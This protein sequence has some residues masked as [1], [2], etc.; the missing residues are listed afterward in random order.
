[1]AA[2]GGA[3]LLVVAGFLL[4]GKR[5]Q[6]G[7]EPPA[8]AAAT[9]LPAPRANPEAPVESPIQVTP[10]TANLE[11]KVNAV[12]VDSL[13]VDKDKED[14]A[15]RH[16]LA[17]TPP[18]PT[19]AQPPKTEPTTAPKPAASAPVPSWLQSAVAVPAQAPK[20]PPPKKSPNSD[21]FSKRF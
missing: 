7:V 19:S 12:S 3:A 11:R 1:M 20:Q 9:Q 2:V 10:S 6:T 4:F 5:D 13:P 14:E 8:A 15:T 17:A 16:P 21:P 18:V